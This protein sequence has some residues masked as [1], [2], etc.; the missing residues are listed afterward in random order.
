M[1]GTILLINASGTT[2]GSATRAAT[3]RLV[4][5]LAPAKI[6]TRDLATTPLPQIDGD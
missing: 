1:S 6:I 2:E 3:A 5:E 4:T